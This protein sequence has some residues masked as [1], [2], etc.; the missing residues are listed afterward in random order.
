MRYRFDSRLCTAGQGMTEYVIIVALMAI[1][2]IAIIRVVSTHM[3]ASFG[4]VAN[5]LQGKETNLSPS[6]TVDDSDIEGKDMG[7][8]TEGVEN[9]N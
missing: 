3:K 5:A 8:F 1:A 2:S 6:E 9:G 7:S 4:D